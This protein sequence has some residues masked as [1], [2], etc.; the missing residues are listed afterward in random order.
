MDDKDQELLK[1]VKEN[2]IWRLMLTR[3][4]PEQL[5]REKKNDHFSRDRDLKIKVGKVKDS[6]IAKIALA[7]LFRIDFFKSEDQLAE[8]LKTPF[9]SKTI[10]DPED[11]LREWR[12]TNQKHQ[13]D[14]GSI[15]KQ[16]FQTSKVKEIDSESIG[17]NAEEIYEKVDEESDIHEPAPPILGQLDIPEQE[18]N[19]D[20]KFDPWWKKLGLVSNPF[21]DTDGLGNIPNPMREQVVLLTEIFKQYI[22]Y[23]NKVPSELFKNTI[24]Y[25]EFGSGKT[26]LFEY[27]QIPLIRNNI[28]SII[29]R[30][31]AEPD[32]QNFLLK[33]KQKLCREL[34]NIFYLLTATNLTA[35]LEA[36]TVDD[37]IIQVIKSIED[38]NRCA[39]FVIFIDDIYKPPDYE[40]VALVF[41]N[42]LQT[43]KAELREEMASPNIGF[44]VSAPPEW[45]AILTKNPAYSG[46]VSREEHMPLPNAEQARTMLNE[47]LC[48]F[49]EDKEK[50]GQIE[51]E[52]SQQVYRT[53]VSRKAFTFRQFIK[54]CLRR[55]ESGDFAIL[56]LNP[57]IISPST[58]KEISHL[59]K[60]KSEI[61]EGINQILDS[62]LPLANKKACFQLLVQIFMQKNC[63]VDSEMFL[64]NKQ[65]F[66]ILKR[67]GLITESS[68]SDKISWTISRELRDFDKHIKDNF[69]YTFDEYFL[70]L[71]K[72]KLEL[73]DETPFFRG[74]EF[75]MVEDLL[76]HL[77]N[78]N[79]NSS[80]ALQSYLNE[81]LAFHKGIVEEIEKSPI[82]IGFNKLKAQCNDSLDSLSKAVATHAGIIASGVDFWN[83]FWIYPDSL[84][85]YQKVLQAQSIEA[86]PSKIYLFS[87]YESAFSEIVSFL[88]DEVKM[89]NIMVIP[90][91]GLKAEEIR[92]FVTTRADYSRGKYVSAARDISTLVENKLREFIYSVF[93]LQYGDFNNRIQRIPNRFH[94]IIRGHID[95]DKKQGFTRTRNE[96]TYLNRQHYFDILVAYDG[97]GRENWTNTFSK[98]FAG[99]NMMQMGSYLDLFYQ[100]NL[101]SA[102]NKEGVLTEPNQSDVYRF[103]V[104][105]IRLVVMMNRSYSLFLE[106]AKKTETPGS[107]AAEYYFS[108]NQNKYSVQPIRFSVTDR[109][110]I[111][112]RLKDSINS[113]DLSDAI[114]LEDR[115]G[116]AYRELF[117]IL[118]DLLRDDNI[119]TKFKLIKKN[120]PVIVL[121]AE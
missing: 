115:Y 12:M 80:A 107:S 83:N 104:E 25:G 69:S 86:N 77:R 70:K 54:E 73:K 38:T 105:S 33:F 37:A 6:E 111:L 21:P 116:I 87:A 110:R 47:R 48:A 113:I 96:L 94:N 35:S 88:S 66:S 93:A 44:F 50:C 22:H 30:L 36:L 89:S 51:P 95:K 27:L 92:K 78:R 91:K 13:H 5:Y 118:A 24:F 16:E 19:E 108:L 97:I 79:D 98:I 67:A 18:A 31:N 28:Q 32:Y 7:H 20:S 2:K 9:F 71:F 112:D 82:R 10:F 102:H 119:G 53:L 75:R 106:N 65:Y 46:S 84:Y 72:G 34:T 81:A 76:E 40:K 56:T 52:F 85:H 121:R 59:L 1:F 60:Q 57:V 23:I 42:Q 17:Y 63:S 101:V 68:S 109:Q 61:S 114:S 8:A 45:K 120:D 58:L 99:W 15:E 90:L 55:F 103:M 62:S 43:F 26:T 64:Q 49:A 74:R 39:G 14:L 4:F 11:Y 100:L 117:A 29:I 41:L 3:D